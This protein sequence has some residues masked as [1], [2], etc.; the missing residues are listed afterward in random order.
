MPGPKS[1][2]GGGGSGP[3]VVERVKGRVRAVLGSTRTLGRTG[4]TGRYPGSRSSSGIRS[5]SVGWPRCSHR[6]MPTAAEGARQ[7]G[8]EGAKPTAA[9]GARQRGAG[10]V[11]PMAAGGVRPTGMGGATP[12][13]AGGA[14]PT[15]VATAS[16]VESS[17][18]RGPR[19][20]EGPAPEASPVRVCATLWGAKWY[21]IQ[22]GSAGRER[23]RPAGCWRAGWRPGWREGS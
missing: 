9:E 10:A 12:T 22:G 6:A 15:G 4:R 23:G 17:R 8:A 13:G 1:P 3:G 21:E 11:R 20:R 5:R 7:R 18:S 2:R 16:P 14:R 19:P